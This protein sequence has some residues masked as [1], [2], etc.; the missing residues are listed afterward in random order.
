MGIQSIMGSIVT[1][2]QCQRFPENKAFF[3]EVYEVTIIVP[4]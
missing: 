2:G 3:G 4:Q 1:M